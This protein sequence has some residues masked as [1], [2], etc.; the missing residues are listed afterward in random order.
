MMLKLFPVVVSAFVSGVVSCLAPH[1]QPF[2][3]LGFPKDTVVLTPDLVEFIQGVVESHH[4][5]GLSLAVVR[6]DGKSEFA[7]WGRKTEDGDP[8]TPD[9]LFPIASCSKAFVSTAIGILIDDYAH[10]RNTTPLPAGL[11]EL[12]W[13]TR[14]KDILPGEWELMDPWASEKANLVD[15]LSHVSGLPR[16]DFSHGP[17]DTPATVVRDLRH[18]RPAFELRQQWSY[19]NQM[20][21]VGAYLISRFTGSYTDF[22]NDRIF[23]PLNMTE[24]TYSPN[25]AHASGKA[26]QTWS[27][28]GRRIPWW[29]S[30]DWQVDLSMGPGGV[31]SSVEDLEKWVQILING[32]IDTRTKTTIIPRSSFDTIVSAHTIARGNPVV[33]REPAV[34]TYGLG[35]ERTVFAG[36]DIIQH[37]GGIP[38]ASSRVTASPIDRIG[39]VVLANADQK[40][41]AITLISNATLRR[42]LGLE[43]KFPLIDVSPQ[44]ASRSTS[45]LE[46]KETPHLPP[47]DLTGTYLNEAY[48]TIVLCNTSSRSKHCDKVLADY[49]TVHGVAPPNDLFAE[50]RTLW[51]SHVHFTHAENNIWHIFPTY[52]FPEGY[53]RD[54]APFS[55]E[56]VFGPSVNFVFEDREIVGF[57]LTGAVEEGPTVRQKEGGSVQYT[58]EV[59][60]T[61]VY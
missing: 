46:P 45:T 51:S 8:A 34:I 37:D 35:W 13:D 21:M 16:H 41:A 25:A 57:G 44:E 39:M 56:E 59:W 43:D 1:Q 42:A 58:S 40:E 24:T 10:G 38:G 11:K 53:G 22:V 20:Y 36:H 14:L 50:F 61:K 49:R 33:L 15:I 47:Y 4:V 31:I 17:T 60:F 54:T 7:S 55:T 23:K 19:N 29:F 32:G 12:N 52:L 2:S 3:S 27:S 30:E 6:P 26:T 28:L 18:L 5:P 9:T 48:G